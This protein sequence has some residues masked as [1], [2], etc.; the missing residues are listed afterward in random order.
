MNDFKIINIDDFNTRF[1]ILNEKFINSL[2]S[3]SLEIYLQI[4]SV[5][6][7]LFRNYII[8][9]LNLKKY[10]DEL[11][12]SGLNYLKVSDENMDIYQDFSKNDLNYFYLRNNLYIERLSIEEKEFLYKIF[13]GDKS[14]TEEQ[15]KLFIENTYYKV[16]FENVNNDGN[17]LNTNYGPDSSE[18][19]VSNN[20]LVI[21]VRYDQFNLNGMSDKEWD[22][23]Y[24]KQT[25]NLI[26]VIGKIEKNENDKL[27]VP[28]NIIVYD[29][30]SIKKKVNKMENIN[31]LI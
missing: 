31:N 30:Y 26:D 12:N 20:S 25:F 27:K 16:I 14:I 6:S 29:D 10:D 21:G 22:D 13:I 5:Y 9:T 19:Y 2:D 15:I 3:E 7:K 8:E 1:P 28:V 11:L 4:Y 18:F 24:Q 23:L 17:I